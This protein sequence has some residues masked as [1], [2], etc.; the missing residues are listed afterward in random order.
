MHFTTKDLDWT[1]EA[2]VIPAQARDALVSALE[3]RF[4]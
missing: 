4:K 1:V 2:G 3:E